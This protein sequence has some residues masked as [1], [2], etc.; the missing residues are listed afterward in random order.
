MR[1]L[2]KALVAIL[3]AVGF[4]TVAFIA[5]IWVMVVQF[6]SGQWGLSPLPDSM[7]LTLDLDT[8]YPE[9]PQNTVRS[10]FEDTPRSL[11]GVVEG[12]ERAASDPAVV[13]LVARISA[14][15]HSLAEAQELREALLRF[16]D[17]GKPMMIFSETLGEGV[18]GLTDMVLVSAFE[19]VWL[20]PSGMVALN[21][22][23][24]EEPYLGEALAEIGIEADGSQR[25][26][27]KTAL[28]GFTRNEMSDEHRESLNRLLQSWTDQAAA[29]LVQGRGLDKTAIARLL[30]GPPLQAAEAQ[31]A[32]LI[33][34]LGYRDEF[35][36]SL[37]RRVGEVER[38]SV[39]LYAHSRAQHNPPPS[40]A[41]P[42]AFI[43]AV[44][45]IHR[46]RGDQGT[47][48]G[49][50]LAEAIQDAL[51]NDTIR[52]IVLRI[53]SP[54][55]S[56]VASDTVWRAL[57]LARQQGV[58]VVASMGTAAA[59]G[60]YMIAMNASHIIAQPATITGSI[61]VFGVKPVFSGLWERLG[62]NWETVNSGDYGQMW[63]MNRPFTEAQRRAFEDMLDVIYDDFTAK[64]AEARSLTPQ[65]VDE[66]AR[67]RLWSGAEA[68]SLGLIDDLGGVT[69]ALAYVRR[70][71]DLPEDAALNLIPFPEPQTP[72]D[73]F[74]SALDSFEEAPL[75]MTTARTL[76]QG[77][78][79]LLV[80]A[81]R[82]AL[83]RQGGVLLP[84]TPLPQPSR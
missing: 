8:Y 56:Y 46:G 45:T 62:V 30:A 60:G 27:Y 68:R 14:T 63:S 19:E 49:D 69:K 70:T 65:Q 51:E 35:R 24:T 44:G 54:G 58:P 22:Y 39:D 7:V 50:T 64:V 6:S 10:L 18:A 72:F 52:A 37:E 43:Q 25:W 40:D 53:D 33:D 73:A 55:G 74:L 83:A 36:A 57:E 78:S 32:G 28:E 76:L 38:V 41:T 61:G 81:E 23:S 11:R 4:L 42:V 29:A 71:L 17:S 15:P 59:S 12:V 1:F 77:A 47:I 48:G 13:G 21:A 2:G 31:Q 82:A 5:L 34:F 9:A 75:L 84:A 26:E 20:Q 66:V 16:R 3:A 79:P 67:G 80:E